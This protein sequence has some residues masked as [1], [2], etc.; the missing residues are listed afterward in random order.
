M[1]TIVTTISLD[2]GR[3]IDSG[4]DEA[5]QS[6]ADEAEVIYKHSE[7][8]FA[9]VRNP[10]NYL[11]FALTF[12]LILLP[13]REFRE[14]RMR[15][16]TKSIALV[17]GI[18]LAAIA[19]PAV[20]DP[21]VAGPKVTFDTFIAVPADSANMQPGGAFSDFDAMF[22]DPVT[23]R[24]FIADRSNAAVD[25]FSGRGEDPSL[26]F[27]GR[28]TGFTGQQATTSVSGPNGVLT[29]TSGGVTT[30]YAG[31]GNSTL[32]IFNATN[33][34]AP[35]VLQAPIST[36]G[37]TRVDEMA[38]SPSSH[39]V[40]AANN[41][42]TP[43]YGNLFATTNGTS[44]VTF[45]NPA[46]GII[47]PASQGGITTGGMEQP[48]W[49]PKTGTFFVSIPQLGIGGASDPGG[50]A[51]IDTSGNVLRTI[52]F[53]TL[54]IGSCSPTGLAVG[55][56]GNLMVG[57]GNVGTQAILLNPTGTGSIVETFAELAGTDAVWYDPGTNAYYIPGNNG[58]D[59][60]RFFDIVT[61]ALAG[62][63]IAQT[64][65]LPTTTSAHSITVDPINGDVF[66]ALAG[67]PA[68]DPC[69]ATQAN[70][71]CIAVYSQVAAVPEP[72]SLSLLVIGL[73]GLTGL[74]VRRRFQKLA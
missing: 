12:A 33:P 20:A 5:K 51:E 41:A 60:T 32:K 72:G 53:S 13:V 61:D 44:P 71:G 45:L 2:S 70:P 38:Y 39:Q 26:T 46:E 40:L 21:V 50:V 73:A 62:G 4:V 49:D 58:S 43:A 19:G 66:V 48:A 47:V 8:R 63:V 23:G 14:E 11:T 35:S 69:P 27:L 28:A 34:A 25:I 68:V 64:V 7:I 18:T 17:G 54:G 37:T 9:P 6:P 1:P 56:S 42:E 57:C 22:A 24:I 10:Y 59:T 36:N 16:V 30:L 55:A 65:N 15:N 52:S 74:A 3:T 29:V 67:T 31:D